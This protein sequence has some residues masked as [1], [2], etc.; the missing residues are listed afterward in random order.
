M[1]GKLPKQ[2]GQSNLHRLPQQ[3]TNNG[4]AYRRQKCVS[5]SSWN[6]KIWEKG[7]S[8]LMSGENPLPGAKSAIFLLTWWKTQ[9]FLWG[10]RELILSLRDEDKCPR[11]AGQREVSVLSETH[12]L[13]F[14][15][16]ILALILC[17]GFCF[18]MWGI[19]F[20]QA[21]WN[22]WQLILWYRGKLFG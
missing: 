17:F 3:N 14:L 2:G 1:V 5:P 22:E 8:I 13:L 6:R 4:M 16:F 19:I 18:K 10:S 9:S 15:E 21:S 12:P 20:L 11:K 7:T